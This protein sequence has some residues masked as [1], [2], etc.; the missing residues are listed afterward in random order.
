MAT[1]PQLLYSLDHSPESPECGRDV[2]AAHH[3]YT[4]STR[5]VASLHRRGVSLTIRG[6][7]MTTVSCSKSETTAFFPHFRATYGA[8]PRASC[9]IRDRGAPSPG[10]KAPPCARRAGQG[11]NL[12]GHDIHAYVDLPPRDY[13]AGLQR[14]VEISEMARLDTARRRVVPGAQGLQ[15]QRPRVFVRATCALGARCMRA[16]LMNG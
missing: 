15:W 3:R 5:A 16:I 14:H 2:R 12:R 7:T 8:T 13:R 1:L 11:S 9:G 10:Q 4:G 6:T